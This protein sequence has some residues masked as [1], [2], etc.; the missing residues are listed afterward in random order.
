MEEKVLKKRKMPKIEL[1]CYILAS[2]LLA[3]AVFMCITSVQYILSYLT[4]YGMSFADMWS[5][6]VQYLIS[7]CVPYL[8]YA[9]LVFCAGRML[10]I[11]Q[12]NNCKEKE[13][14]EDTIEEILE[15]EEV[16]QSMEIEGEFADVQEE[17]METKEE[18][19]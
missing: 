17:S 15:E 12:Q 3:V 5:D 14:T 18:Q 11:V 7:G 9:I 6:S 4:S 13:V 16:G 10:G 8:V 2:V 1:C 19:L